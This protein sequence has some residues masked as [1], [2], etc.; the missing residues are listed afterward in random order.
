MVGDEK[1]IASSLATILRLQGFEATPF[2]EPQRALEAACSEAPDLLISDVVMPALSGIDLA[3]RV[4]QH[5]PDC[6]IL[7]FPG[8]A[9][10]PSSS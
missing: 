7:L 4:Q 8:Q 6:K 3:I 10:T 1:V 2:T 9:A 5:C